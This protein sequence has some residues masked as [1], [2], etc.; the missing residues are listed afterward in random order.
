MSNR[1]TLPILGALFVGAALLCGLVAL[2]SSQRAANRVKGLTPVT[3]AVLEDS[4]PGHKV[5]IEGH[6]S[7]R[8]PVQPLSPGFVAYIRE[9]REIHTDDEG[10]PEP[11]SWSERGRVTP[12]LLLELSGGLVQIENDDYDLENGRTVEDEPSFFDRYSDTRY[13]G[14]EIGDPVIAVG[15]VGAA[16]EPPQI[17]ADFIARGTQTGY[18]A[19]QRSAGVI[20]LVMSVV[21]AAVG[22]IF[23]MWD[24]VTGLLPKR[25]RSILRKNWNL[26]RILVLVFSVL[27]VSILC[28]G[29]SVFGLRR[30]MLG[31]VFATVGGGIS[32]LMSLVLWLLSRRR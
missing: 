3:V 19:S 24:R 30:S 28:V 31:V 27:G 17:K 23:I 26:N 29:A 14:V 6:I 11:G 1:K 20:F 8:N 25:Q 21:V 2:Y 18:I 15:V 9:E 10:T 7:G 13:K 12:P 22:G 32:M 4:Q 16:A 5:L